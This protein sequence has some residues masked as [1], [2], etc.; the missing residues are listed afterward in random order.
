MLFLEGEQGLAQGFFF[1]ASTDGLLLFWLDK[2]DGVIIAGIRAAKP[3]K[4]VAAG[5]SVL[6]RRTWRRGPQLNSRTPFAVL[7]QPL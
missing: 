3:K 7:Q 4:P 6:G 5:K 1:I 2:W